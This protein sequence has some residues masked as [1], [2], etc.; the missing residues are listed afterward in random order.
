MIF[1]K[2]LECEYNMSHS[3]ILTVTMLNDNTARYY[4][5]T[6]THILFLVEVQKIQYYEQY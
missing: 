6:K 3:S 1:L 2:V 5:A 4:D